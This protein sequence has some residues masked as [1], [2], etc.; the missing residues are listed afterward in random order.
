MQIQAIVTAAPYAD[1][2]G[3]VIAHPLV[4]GLRLNTVMPTVS[5]PGEAL[6]RLA[7]LGLP[8]WVDLKGRQLRVVGSAV[9]PFTEV[10]LSHAIE[11]PTPVTAY[12]SDG[13]EAARVMAV[14]GNRLILEH[15]PRRVI[16]PG[17][18]VNIVHPDLKVHGTLTATDIAYL[19]AMAERGLQR[20]ML[21]YVE[22]P[23]D[24]Q[25]VRNR[26][27]G[28][29]VLLKIETQKGLS[30]AQAHGAAHG[31]LVVARGDL[32]IELSR[33]HHILPA[34]KTIIQADPLA[35]VASRLFDAMAFEPVPHCAEIG[36]AAF[37]LS[38]GYRSF[39][40]GDAVCLQKEPLLE[41]LNLLQ[42]IGRDWER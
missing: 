13:L 41:T 39:L 14:D 40:L 28:A 38:L 6:D 24:V 11:V 7:N 15:G 35:I 19:T 4:A 37:L 26:L 32:Y 16:G 10:T 27:P 33:P 20:V 42:A 25:E 31:H 17:E 18:S 12:F 29:D 5:G 3:E 36:D 2:L 23:E 1:F 34:L 9:P 8:L 30:F 21:S 22:S